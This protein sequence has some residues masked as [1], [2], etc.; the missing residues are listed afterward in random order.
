MI[1]KRYFYNVQV[2]HFLLSYE[3][4]YKNIVF[5]PI[6]LLL[7]YTTYSLI[8]IFYLIHYIAGVSSRDDKSLNR[9]LKWE[10]KHA[11]SNRGK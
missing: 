11:V 6:V 7:V 5:F 1:F 3:N 8:V 9:A 4:R 2:N 10:I